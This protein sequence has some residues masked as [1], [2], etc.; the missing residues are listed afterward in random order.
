[1][2]VCSTFNVLADVKSCSD[3]VLMM[4]ICVGWEEGGYDSGVETILGFLT[5]L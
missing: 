1:M 4:I 2:L 3:I 5:L